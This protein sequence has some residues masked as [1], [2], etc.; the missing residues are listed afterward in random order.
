MVYATVRRPSVRPIRPP[1][2]AAVGLLLCAWWSGYMLH[3]MQWQMWAVPCCRHAEEAGHRL[4]K[5]DC[6]S[7]V[8]SGVSGQLLQRL[9]SVFNDAAHLVFSARNSEHI[10]PLFCE[11]HWLKVPER[12]Q[13]RLCVL[14]YRY[15]NGTAASYLAETLHLTADVGSRRR[16]RGAS[17]FTLVI[18]ST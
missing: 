7:S 10:T 4:T 15:I 13:F 1:H 12:I 5:V 3:G 18:P 9:Q 2:A 6:C 17:T 8:L 16:L 14:T 11:L